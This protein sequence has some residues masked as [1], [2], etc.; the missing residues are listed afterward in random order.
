[1]AVAPF[2]MWGYGYATD[3]ARV[4]IEYGLRDLR[5]HRITAAI[6]PD[7]EASIA[8]VKKLGFRYEGRLRDHVFTNDAWR[9]SLL[10]SVLAQD[11]E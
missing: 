1:M 5:L 7:N 6:G 8:V 4:I 3:A 9:D 2:P 11:W 10:F